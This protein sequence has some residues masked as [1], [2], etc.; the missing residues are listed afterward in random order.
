MGLVAAGREGRTG[1]ASAAVAGA[2]D[3]RVRQ[4][5]PAYCAKF[6]TVNRPSFSW[7]LAVS[8]W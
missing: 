5:V 7:P 2:L 6:T 8:M 3:Q 1:G 4:S